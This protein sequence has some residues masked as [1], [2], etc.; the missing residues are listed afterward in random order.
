MI[1]VKHF[2][3]NYRRGEL[4]LSENKIKWWNFLKGIIHRNEIC[5]GIF[6][7][8][9]IVPTI[10][11]SYDEDLFITFD[12]TTFR[13]TENI[14]VLLTNEGDAKA[15]FYLYENNKVLKKYITMLAS[16]F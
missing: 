7:Y 13:L 8:I 3:K 16:L 6:G 5:N 9:G 15:I 14:D 11:Y 2:N 4:I 12:K 10:I 1:I